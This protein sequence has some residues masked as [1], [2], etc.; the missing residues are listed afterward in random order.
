MC[1]FASSKYVIA[2]MHISLLNKRLLLVSLL[3]VFGCGGAYSQCPNITIRERVDHVRSRFCRQNGWDTVV[4]CRNKTLVL[5]A[6]VFIT[7]QHFNGTYLVEEIPYNP[8]EPFTFGTRMPIGTDDDFGPTIDINFPFCF[9]GYRKTKI[10]LG[11]NG[12]GTFTVGAG[13]Q[14][15]P[16]GYS[17][18]LPWP[19]NT[20]GAPNPLTHMRDAIYGVYEDTYPPAAPAPRG[21]YYGSSPNSDFPCRH[22]CFSWNHVP[23][24][25]HSGADSTTHN[26]TY[27]IVIYEGTNIIEVHV[28]DRMPAASWNDSRGIIGIQNATGT[29]QES[30]YHDYR[31]TSDPSYYIE[32][33]KPAFFAPDG[34]NPFTTAIHHR[35]WRFTP[36]GSETPTNVTWWRLIERPGDAAQ[37]Y[38]TVQFS[39]DPNDTNGFYLQSN[40]MKVR[41]T[42]RGVTKYLVKMIYESATG[43]FYNLQ[44]TILVGIDTASSFSLF[45]TDSIICEGQAATVTMTYPT[46][47]QTLDSCTWRAVKIFNGVQTEMPATAINDNF[48]SATLRNQAGNLTRNHIDSVLLYCTAQ[49]KNGCT[50]YDSILIRTYPNFD[51]YDTMGICAGESYTWCGQTYHT[52]GD[53]TKHYTSLAQCDSNIHLHLMTFPPTYSIDYVSD[54]APHTWING[55]TY[56]A[57]ND[58]TRAQDTILLHNAWGCDSVVSLNFTFIPMKAI[59]THTPEVATLDNLTIEL[60]DMSYGH[61]SR[62]WLLPNGSTATGANTFVNFPLTGVDSLKVRLAIH[63]NYGCDDTASTVIM[64]HKV[65]H[66]VPNIFTPDRYDNNTFTP[67]VRGNV[68]DVQVWILNRQGQQ[69]YYFKGPDGFWDGTDSHGQRCPQGS[70]VY[71]LR[72]RDSL[73]PN[74]TQEYIGTITLVR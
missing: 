71:I 33:D 41:V 73:E 68:S 5:N 2:A 1:I 59:I 53:Y 10:T 47:R 45:T 23:Q 32:P 15:C 72:Y 8:P 50:R 6:D 14:D 34:F 38:D 49:F 13:N 26:C 65:S 44:D 21:I 31:Y 55:R 63:N 11:A 30:H 64:L 43:F 3:F 74:M 12:L 54:C 28:A 4:N 36:L 57:N 25:N 27:Q 56:S 60:T 37:P 61:D 46:E 58:D 24:F 29:T 67:K 39:F 66:F 17:V 70:Y 7:T 18:G 52:A 22:I 69:I 35:A 48:V 42:P 9:F 20:S 19:N 51:V 62:T 40:K 16:W